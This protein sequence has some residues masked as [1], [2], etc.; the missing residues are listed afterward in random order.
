MDTNDITEN[1]GLVKENF[2]WTQVGAITVQST[3]I[4]S[5][6]SSLLIFLL[7][8]SQTSEVRTVNQLTR[9]NQQTVQCFSLDIYVAVSIPTCFNPQ[10]IIL[11][12]LFKSPSNYFFYYKCKNPKD[13]NLNNTHSENLK[14]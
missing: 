7:C 4:T 8:L 3:S 12:E 1:S 5:V 9:I 10:G 2:Q 14:F 6:I 11:R 13:T